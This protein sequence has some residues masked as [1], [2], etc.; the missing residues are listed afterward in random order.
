M[1]EYYIHVG[2][3]L[4][5]APFPTTKQWEDVDTRLH[6]RSTCWPH[7]ALSPKDSRFLTVVF[8]GYLQS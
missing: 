3:P 6:F 1:Y 7:P 8:G 5:P 2:K 4:P